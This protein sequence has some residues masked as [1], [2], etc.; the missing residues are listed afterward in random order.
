[1]CWHARLPKAVNTAG[2]ACSH[3]EQTRS[4][5]RARCQIR[6]LGGSGWLYAAFRQFAARHRAGRLQGTQLRHAT[7]F[8]GVALVAESPSAVIVSPKIGAR[9]LKVFIEDAK[10]KPETFTYASAGTGSQT[11]L[12]AEYFSSQ[13][14][15]KLVH[16]PYHNT[17]SIIADMIAGRTHATFSP[18][19][20]L[21]GQI[22]SGDLWVLAVTSRNGMA[23]PINA[24]SVNETVIPGYQYS[25]WL[26]FLRLRARQRQFWN[27]SP[28][29]F[30][31]P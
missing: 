9:T 6:R 21:L 28:T 15:I 22:Q 29:P 30:K 14:G 8:A 7:D 16:L 13:A 4:R 25:T 26:A 20:F 12:A 24:P 27:G 31:Q 2:Q 5:R 19:G 1:M 3:R 17:G 18:P 23:E 11:H 10:S